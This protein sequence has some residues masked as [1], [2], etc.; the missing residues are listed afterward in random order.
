[1]SGEMPRYR[2]SRKRSTVSSAQMCIRDRNI[3]APR[4]VERDAAAREYG[5]QHRLR[6]IHIARG[7]RNIAEAVA[8]AAHQTQNFRGD[9]LRLVVSGGGFIQPQLLRWLVP[10]DITAE[11]M[12]LH[13]AERIARRAAAQHLLRA[14]NAREMCIRD[15]RCPAR[16]A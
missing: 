12:L 2:S 15:R 6:G 13:M 11:E 9:P 8:L 14:G 16:R 3:A 7:D 5:A 1:M 4:T 10:A